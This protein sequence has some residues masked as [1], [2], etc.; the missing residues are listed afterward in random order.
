MQAQAVGVPTVTVVVVTYDAPGDLL[1]RCLRS[2]LETTGPATAASAAFVVDRLVVVDNGGRAA[3]RLVEAGLADDVT[4]L[5]PGANDG[6]A[7]GVNVGCR[8]AIDAAADVVVVLN[9]DVD[10]TS[11]W[12]APLMAELANDPSIAAAQPA[13]LSNRYPPA[14]KRGTTPHFTKTWR[15]RVP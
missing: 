7:A 11:D 14:R 10:V 13:S 3:Q 2:V 8:A 12:L 5:D 9:D 4:L 15:V 1:E 6:F